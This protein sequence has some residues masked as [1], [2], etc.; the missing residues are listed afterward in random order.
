MIRDDT[1]VIVKQANAAMD[2]AAVVV[3]QRARQHNAP[4]V[5]WRDGKVIELDPF[6][7]EFGDANDNA[8]ASGTGDK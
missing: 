6:S 4:I 5:V 8:T 7:P 3:L 1:P 2:E